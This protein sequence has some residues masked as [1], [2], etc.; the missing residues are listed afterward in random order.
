MDKKTIL[1]RG[2]ATNTNDS[3]NRD[4]VKANVS[5]ISSETAAEI[6]RE[7]MEGEYGYRL[8]QLMEL[9]GLALAL[10]V[11]SDT[12][13]NWK[14]MGSRV[15]VVCGP[16]NNGGDG[17][18]AARHLQ[19]MRGENADAELEDVCVCYPAREKL[20]TMNAMSDAKAHYVRLVQQCSTCGVRFI[21]VEE[22]V[23]MMQETQTS[24]R[25]LLIDCVFGFSFH[26]S[27]RSP[28]DSLIDGMARRDSLKWQCVSCDI[29][30]GWQVDT[31]PDQST[32]SDTTTAMLYPDVL[33]SLTAPKLCAIG[34][35]GRHYL[36]GRFLPKALNDKFGITLPMYGSTGAQIVEIR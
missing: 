25:G 36:G 15:L 12:S 26:G 27:P 20:E 30:S 10:A 9:A 21:D 28:Y 31:A 34:F 32:D 2:Y 3:L 8:E 33:V 11:S 29:P 6:D 19:I 18:V 7:L 22:A 14:E 17:L 16:G 4:C 24:K 35:K 23:A 1:K 5:Y 13:G